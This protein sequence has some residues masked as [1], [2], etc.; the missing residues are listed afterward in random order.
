MITQGPE[1]IDQ[2]TKRN[3]YLVDCH[4]VLK[5][6]KYI[7]THRTSMYK[8]NLN[9]ALLAERRWFLMI[10]AGQDFSWLGLNPKLLPQLHYPFF[11]LLS[12]FFCFKAAKI[13][14]WLFS[15]SFQ[16]PLDQRGSCY[17][18]RHLFLPLPFK[19]RQEQS[20]DTH[21]LVSRTYGRKSNNTLPSARENFG[22]L[23]CFQ[24]RGDHLGQFLGGI[25]EHLRNYLYWNQNCTNPQET[26]PF[27]AAYIAAL[28]TPQSSEA[29]VKRHCFRL[30]TI[31]MLW[32]FKFGVFNLIIHLSVDITI[33]DFSPFSSGNGEQLNKAFTV[34]CV[35]S[36][37]LLETK[38]MI[39][40]Y[41]SI[42]L[43]A[44]PPTPF[45]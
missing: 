21:I 34:G 12:V 38:L 1:T 8:Y 30:H 42:L 43:S 39:L 11:Q 3:L 41:L 23:H 32:E 27:W 33:T 6:I 19:T 26:M 40:C 20:P 28:Q 2:I 31:T 17:K 29:T 24:A 22:R 13:F 45:N 15:G 35:F 25:I 9:T 7:I 16:A 18:L 5:P 36:P 44:P 4:Y 10:A 37:I 14:G